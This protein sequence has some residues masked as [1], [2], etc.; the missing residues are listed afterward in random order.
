MHINR[1]IRNRQYFTTEEPFGPDFH[2]KT[3]RD[4]KYLLWGANKLFFTKTKKSTFLWRD[5]LSKTVVLSKN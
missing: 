4:A 5:Q 1:L 3:M 2:G